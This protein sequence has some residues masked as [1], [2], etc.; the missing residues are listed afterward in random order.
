M[1]KEGR[2][3][4]REREK[5]EERYILSKISIYIIH[6]WLILLEP[7]VFVQT[8]LNDTF[9]YQ[10]QK[11]FYLSI[12]IS[13]SLFLVISFIF[14]SNSSSLVHPRR[15]SSSLW[16]WLIM[17]LL[18]LLSRCCCYCHTISPIESQTKYQD[19]ETLLNT[20]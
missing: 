8:L 4:E 17:L 20:S 3:R 14:V 15:G 9:R 10:E 13:L 16:M 7:L 2:D 12:S 6:L 18:L 5:C 11:W 19:R 1:Q